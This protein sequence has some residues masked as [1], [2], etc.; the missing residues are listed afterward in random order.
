[1]IYVANLRIGDIVTR[2]SYG[3]DMQFKITDIVAGE[4]G[5]NKCILRGLIYRILADCDMSDVQLIDKR[6]A[7]AKLYKEVNKV[8]SAESIKKY[9]VP[10]PHIKWMRGTYGNILHIDS[11]AEFLKM[12]TDYYRDAGLRANSIVVGEREQPQV[13][14]RLLERYNPDILVLTGHDSIKKDANPS[15]LESYTNSRYFIESV[16]TARKYQPDK[17]SLFIFAGACQSYYEA[18]MD[19]GANFASSPGRILIH[20]LDPG[21]V[22]CKIAVTDRSRLVTPSEIIKLTNS[23]AKGIGGVSSRGHFIG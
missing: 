9:T 14:R 8:A 12:C 5:K 15:S 22:S 23:G 3:G 11:S 1:M 21:I 2:K 7:L 17:N 6:E 20:A 13:V 4:D 18:I 16:K 19:S 10:V